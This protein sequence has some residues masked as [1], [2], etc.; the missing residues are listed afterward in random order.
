HFRD[1]PG[2][3]HCGWQVKAEVP[4]RGT[5]TLVIEVQDESD[6]WHIA[7]ARQLKRTADDA[8]PPPNTYSS[9][10]AAYDTLTPEDADR[11]RAKLAALTRRPLISVLMPVY[12]TPEKFLIAA[13]ESVRRQ[14][15]D[16]WELCISDDASKQPHVRKILERYQKKDSRIKVVIRETNGHISANS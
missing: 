1:Y 6:A 8:P 15:Y 5:H 10:V 2:A 16:N 11:I 4:R 14:L 7:V 12:E 3:S 9:W 13:I